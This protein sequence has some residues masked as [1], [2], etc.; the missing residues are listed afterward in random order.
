MQISNNELSTFFV[1]IKIMHKFM[2]LET[3]SIRVWPKASPVATNIDFI[4]SVEYWI[5]PKIR[6]KVT[7]KFISL[8][9]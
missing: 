7:R 9:S 2:P 5:T 4:I 1:R 3:K 6:T 8:K